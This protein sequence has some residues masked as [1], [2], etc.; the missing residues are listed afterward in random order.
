[1]DFRGIT[2][3]SLRFRCRK[4]CYCYLL[5][6]G[7]ADADK[8][9]AGVGLDSKLL[10][11]PANPSECKNHWKNAAWNV[12]L[13][14]FVGQLQQSILIGLSDIVMIFMSL[15]TLLQLLSWS[16]GADEDWGKILQ[17]VLPNFNLKNVIRNHKKDYSWSQ[18]PQIHQIS[19][20]CLQ[21]STFL[22]MIQVS[23]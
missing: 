17:F 2:S 1:M 4:S 11:H 13:L 7:V 20:K 21:I 3:I 22:Y 10:A 16:S 14:K 8:S 9:W 5:F 19:R 23:R 12:K 18:C 15:N 6:F